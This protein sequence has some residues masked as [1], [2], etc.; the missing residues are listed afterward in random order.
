VI[1]Q[2]L[3]A[4]ARA[5]RRV[6]ENA[7]AGREGGNRAFVLMQYFG[8]ICAVIRGNAPEPTLDYSGYNFWI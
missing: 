8:Y 5:L 1:P 6:A 3:R 7:Y 4:R 2:T